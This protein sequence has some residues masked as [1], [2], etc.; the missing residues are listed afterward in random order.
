MKKVL[1]CLLIAALISA[2]S[3]GKNK[4]SERFNLLT[5]HIWTSD[6]LLVNGID[7]SGSGQTLE[8]FK[9]DAKFNEDGTGYFGQYIG[10]WMF[11]DNETNLAIDSPD[12]LSPLTTHIVELTETSLK[13]TLTYTIPTTINIRMTFKPK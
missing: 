7:A 2:A 4:T 3:C 8:K 13:V 11:V 10:T 1:Y 5:S 6:S 9:G 12:L